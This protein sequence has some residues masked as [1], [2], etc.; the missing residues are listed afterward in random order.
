MSDEE[1]D[2]MTRKQKLHE[3]SKD[4]QYPR[5]RQKTMRVNVPTLLDVT[6]NAVELLRL[7][8]VLI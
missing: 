3:M 7:R 1:E 2:E 8:N 5:L 6:C 4:K